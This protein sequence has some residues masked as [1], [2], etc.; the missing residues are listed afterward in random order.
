MSLINWLLMLICV[1]IG[2]KFSDNLNY[3]LDLIV[4]NIDYVGFYIVTCLI[5]FLL[6]CKTG[7]DKKEDKY[8]LQN[9]PNGFLFEKIL[10]SFTWWVWYIKPVLKSFWIS[11]KKE[12]IIPK[13]NLEW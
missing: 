11:I 7:R 13:S 5:Q 12:R 4:L 9:W 3:C 10:V 1:T 8:K 2:I 6:F